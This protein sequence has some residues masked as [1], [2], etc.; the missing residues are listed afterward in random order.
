MGGYVKD[1][2]LPETC[3]DRPLFKSNAVEV[4]A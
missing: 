2:K 3:C 4:E 1:M